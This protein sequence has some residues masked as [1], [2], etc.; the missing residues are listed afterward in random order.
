MGIG[1]TVG[2]KFAPKITDL[3]PQYT[4]GFI[5]EALKRAIEG[6]GPLDSAAEAASN[7][8]AKAGGNV[9]E[10]V[11]KTILRHVEY[12]GA[13]GFATN[14]GGL[15]TAAATIPVNITGLALIQVRMVAVIAS[16]RG[17]DL[18]D[19][20][21]QTAVLLCLLGESDVKRVIKEGRIPAPPMAIATAPA[22]DPQLDTTI[23]GVVAAEL[24]SAVAGKR[25]ATTVGRR[26]PVLGG[27][28]GM[29]ADAWSTWRIGRY[30]AKELLARPQLNKKR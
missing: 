19:P 26:V 6:I 28:V 4:H 8:L 16:L 3:A 29:S 20:K 10:A 30:A 15:V 18:A 2:K 11:D 14:I 22:H 25:M 7:K 21:V 27:A 1:S 13:Q 12:A 9:D 5:R 24:L 23:S 17:H